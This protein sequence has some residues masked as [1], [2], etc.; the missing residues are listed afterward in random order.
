MSA[1]VVNKK[2]IETITAKCKGVRY[3]GSVGEPGNN[4]PGRSAIVRQNIKRLRDSRGWSQQELTARAGTSVKM[5]ESGERIGRL[6][7]HQK[8]AKALGVPVWRLY[9]DKSGKK[10]PELDEL[11]NSSAGKSITDE[12]IDFLL[13]LPVMLGRR[14]TLEG[15]TAALQMLRSSEPDPNADDY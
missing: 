11:L 8:F 2:S 3:L 12:Q 14:L 9:V 4:S 13:A 15:Y 6:S 5:I 1:A 7:T 10:P